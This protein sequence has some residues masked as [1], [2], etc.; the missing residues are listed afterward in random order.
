M[1][2]VWVA[3]V[4]VLVVISALLAVDSV[5]ARAASGAVGHRV[6]IVVG[7]ICSSSSS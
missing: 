3:V 7:V 5:S 2:W 4:V 1:G 6:L